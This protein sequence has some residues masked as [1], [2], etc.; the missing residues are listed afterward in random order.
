M[1]VTNPTDGECV[2][3][4]MAINKYLPFALLYFFF[5]SL[6]L[7]FGVTYTALLAPFFYLWIVAARKKDVLI[8]FLVVI[9][10]IVFIQ[11]VFVGVDD[12]VYFISFVNLL[13]VYVF[14]QAVYTFLLKCEEPELVFKKILIVNFVFCLLAVAFYFTPA[15]EVFWVKQALTGGV[16]DF[17]RLKLFTY[18][19]SYYAILV[20]PI[21]FFF[22]LQVLLKQNKMNTWFLL[23]VIVVPLI[24][25]FSLGVIIAILLS[26]SFAS[27]IY[28]KRLLSKWRMVWSVALATGVLVP[29]VVVLFAAFPDNVLLLRLENILFGIDTSGKGRTYEAFFL[30]LKI[31]GLKSNL[32][33]IGLGQ[34]KVIGTN[35]IKDFYL[36][37]VDYKTVAIP[38]A[39]AETLAIFGFAG[40]F[41]RLG[42]EIVLFFYTKVWA[43]YY[44]LLLFIFIFIYQFTGSFITSTAEYVIW[45]LAFTMVFKQFDVRR[46]EPSL[47]FLN[48]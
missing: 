21:F 39:T 35:V 37:T 40:L 42:I 15:R 23:A 7:P 48:Q 43:N 44:R 22:L 29:A 19:P 31:L 26:M 27:A 10:P 9:F 25:S 8:P 20:V 34:I 36:Y 32:W 41:A 16:D 2:Y 13:T 45:I 38:N 3:N 14:C 12:S 17:L 1:P 11:M 4:N 18:E 28:M 46:K 33:G 30:S 5:N 47:P 24:L 6:G